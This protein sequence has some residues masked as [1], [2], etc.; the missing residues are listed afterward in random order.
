MVC[1]TASLIVLPRHRAPPNP[2]PT[3]PRTPRLVQPGERQQRGGW[4]GSGARAGRGASPMPPPV[5]GFLSPPPSA[6]CP[7]PPAPC[8]SDGSP[9]DL[10]L[11]QSGDGSSCRRMCG[12]A[13][14]SCMSRAAARAPGAGCSSRWSS[15]PRRQALLRQRGGVEADC[16]SDCSRRSSARCQR[17]ATRR[18]SPPSAGRC[19]A[20]SRASAEARASHACWSAATPRATGTPHQRAGWR[21][22][23]GRRCA[24]AGTKGEGEGGDRVDEALCDAEH[25]FGPLLPAGVAFSGAKR[26]FGCA[27]CPKFPKTR[28]SAPGPPAARSAATGA[29]C[30][31]MSRALGGMPADE[32]FRCEKSV[33][34]SKKKN[35]A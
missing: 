21:S 20:S 19:A 2:H 17:R 28:G 7:L 4:W 1:K 33:K 12:R 10:S 13:W 3:P 30:H 29:R 8:H 32:V 25:G 26:Y 15:R 5:P 18:C 11:L 14:P 16:Q 24:E 9:S 27:K 23:A 6:S 22:S 31:A 35:N 34:I